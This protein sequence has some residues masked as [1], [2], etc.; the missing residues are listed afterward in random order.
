[1][2]EGGMLSLPQ[3]MTTEAAIVIWG[4]LGIKWAS[5]VAQMVK[6]LP[7]IHGILC[8]Q[9]LNSV[10]YCIQGK[11]GIVDGEMVFHFKSSHF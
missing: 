1:M 3:A 6:N 7:A 10:I 5:L 8:F 11:E 2:C 9:N 4:L